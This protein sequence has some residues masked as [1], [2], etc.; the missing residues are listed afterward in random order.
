MGYFKHIYCE[1]YMQKLRV[2]VD[3]PAESQCQSFSTAELPALRLQSYRPFPEVCFPRRMTTLTRH[4]TVNSTGNFHV[5][6]TP[7][8]HR[9]VHHV[10]KPTQDL[11]SAN[12]IDWTD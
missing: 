3:S 10:V 7:T 6:R 2:T 12:G 11:L 1:K 4:V 9:V 8:P 5:S